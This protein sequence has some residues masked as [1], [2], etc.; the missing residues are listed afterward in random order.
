VIRIGQEKKR[1][2][3]GLAVY[4][5]PE[6]SAISIFRVEREQG[7]LGCL[8]IGQE[9]GRNGEKQRISLPQEE[10]LRGRDRAEE[11]LASLDGVFV[12]ETLSLILKIGKV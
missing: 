1:V 12:R 8:F 11:N 3:Y 7:E 9:R 2:C 5:G 6:M 4:F 10:S